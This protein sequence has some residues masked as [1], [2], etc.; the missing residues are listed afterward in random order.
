[1]HATS[2]Y[3]QMTNQALSYLHMFFLQNLLLPSLPGN[4]LFILNPQ[5]LQDLLGAP[6][7][8]CCS[9]LSV[10]RVQGVSLYDNV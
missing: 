6:F 9:V 2:P 1:M 5:V 3:F 10:S 8:V 4:L 7:P